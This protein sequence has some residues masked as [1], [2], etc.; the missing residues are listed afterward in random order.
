MGS[1]TAIDIFIGMNGLEVKHRSTVPEVSDSIH[2]ITLDGDLP[3]FVIGFCL[4]FCFS[5]KVFEGDTR[6]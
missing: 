4:L 2:K 6:V 1:L 5:Y 3:T